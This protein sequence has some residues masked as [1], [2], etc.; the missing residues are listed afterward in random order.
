MQEIKTDDLGLRLET[1]PLKV[2]DDWT[3][4]FIRGDDCIDLAM[5]IDYLCSKFNGVDISSDFMLDITDSISRKSHALAC[6]MN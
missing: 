5:K 3:G 4:L 6:G 1:G 2:D